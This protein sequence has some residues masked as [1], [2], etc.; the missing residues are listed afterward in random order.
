[1]TTIKVGFSRPIKWKPFAWLIMVA[2]D[3]PYDHVYI[4][5][6]SSEFN[7]QMIFQ[8]SSLVVNLMSEDEFLTKNVIVQEFDVELADDKMQTMLQF[9]G[10]QLGKP[11]GIKECFG[12]AIVRIAE[13]LGKR[14]NNPFGFDG[15]TYVCSELAGYICDQFAGMDIDVDPANI[16]PKMVYNYLTSKFK[17]TQ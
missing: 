16:T 12:L 6:S 4:R 14:I 5:Y 1:M 15:T 10:A 8:A 3:I 13:L 7:S 11:Y 2:Y 9:A 17:S